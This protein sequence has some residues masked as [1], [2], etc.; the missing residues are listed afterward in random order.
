MYSVLLHAELPYARPPAV[1]NSPGVHT[2]PQA[3]GRAAAQ[4]QSHLVV[5]P[6]RDG[7]APLSR[8]VMGS[9]SKQL[10]PGGRFNCKA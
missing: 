8:A 5:G 10:H 3:A 4:V 6:F 1:D 7:D 9:M 2:E